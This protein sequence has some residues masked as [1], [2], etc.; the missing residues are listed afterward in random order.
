MHKDFFLALYLLFGVAA[1]QALVKSANKCPSVLLRWNVDYQWD[2]PM[3][4]IC[5]W[6]SHCDIYW[7]ISFEN[8]LSN[9][10]NQSLWQK[11]LVSC[12]LIKTLRSPRLDA[13]LCICRQWDPY[14]LTSRT[15]AHICHPVYLLWRVSCNILGPLILHSKA[16]SRVKTA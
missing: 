6:Q 1:W 13:M 4:N 15:S 5:R 9:G 14:L 8:T 16:K 12:K 7:P 3:I 10:L 2:Y 11:P